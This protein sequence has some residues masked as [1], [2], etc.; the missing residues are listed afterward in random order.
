MLGLFDDLPIGI[1]N[2]SCSP[3]AGLPHVPALRI[4]RIDDPWIR[5]EHLALVDVAKCPVLISLGF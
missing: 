2:Y 5:A 3:R 4:A 1:L